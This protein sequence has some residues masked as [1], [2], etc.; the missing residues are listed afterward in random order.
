MARGGTSSDGD[1]LTNRT[2]RSAG[3]MVIGAVP[4]VGCGVR[5]QI[6]ANIIRN[7][8]IHRTRSRIQPIGRKP[9]GVPE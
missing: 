8:A 9:I 1:V 7:R 5:C 6:A 4:D 3:F 2:F